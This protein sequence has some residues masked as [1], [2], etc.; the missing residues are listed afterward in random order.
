MQILNI[1]TARE[2]RN[3]MNPNEKCVVITGVTGQ[4]GSNMVDYL[5]Q[6][7]IANEADGLHVYGGARRLSLDNHTN[8]E[9]LKNNENFSL[10]NL[11]I[12]DTTCVTRV[13][14]DLQ[15]DYFINFA[16]QSFV[17]SSWDLPKQ[18]FAVNATAVLDMLEAIRL[19][20][21][22][23]RFYQAGSSE[24]F[25]DVAYA[26]QDEKHPSRPVSP[27]GASK[28]AARALVKV[29]RDS[30]NLYACS[31]F[32]FN[33]EGVR[34]GEEFVTRKI[35]KG[36][37]RIKRAMMDGE[38][39]EPI[40]LGNVNSKRDWSDSEDFVHGVWLMLNQDKPGEYVLSSNETHEIKEFVSL[41]FNAAG[42]HGVW[43]GEGMDEK[44]VTDLHNYILSEV[45]EK[46]YRPAEINLLYGDSSK[47]RKEL[48]WAPRVSFPQLVRKMVSNDL[49][50]LGIDDIS[51]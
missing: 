44:F 13:I 16:A 37:A 15:P 26:P 40:Q 2:I 49:S 31:G 3:E 1:T 12:T 19:Y 38:K 20:A 11:D 39:F 35:T 9:H 46:F 17:G 36:V 24:E 47:A 25:G 10:I 23:C 33:H 27:Y 34:R 29:Y 4:D 6:R 28:V 41:A 45:N 18:T 14:K 30:Y 42:I 51:S 5:L 22:L 32:L 7:V 48:K 43:R 50:L 21:P 8:I